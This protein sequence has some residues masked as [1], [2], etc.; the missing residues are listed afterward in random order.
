MPRVVIRTC[1][2]CPVRRAVAARVASELN[3]AG[4]ST[5]VVRGGLGELSAWLDGRRVFRS[6]GVLVSPSAERVLRQVEEALSG[7][8]AAETAR[9]T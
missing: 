5:E 1:P 2:I 7:A 6:W 9:P 8:A 3:Q 4:T